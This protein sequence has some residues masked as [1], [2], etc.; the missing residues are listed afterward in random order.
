MAEK[1]K[2]MVVEDD[3]FLGL[4]VKEL[5]ESR[6]YDASLFKDGE[7]AQQ[8]FFEE[9][10]D[11]CVL[12]VMLPRKDGFTLAN[13]I[14][15]SGSN[16]PIVFLTAKSMTEDV[17]KGFK[18]GANDYVKKP[19]SMEELLVRVESILQRN[20]QVAAHQ[21]EVIQ[22]QEELFLLGNTHFNYT[23]QWLEVDGKQQ[24][25][26]P[27]EAE[28]LKMLCSERNKVV[29]RKLILVKLWG[30]DT[31]FNGRSLDVFIAKIR[32][33]LKHEPDLKIVTIRGEGYK[34]VSK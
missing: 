21:E 33:M 1:T 14:R 24:T 13:E 28:L 3:P 17:V 12:D 8:A 23:F 29:N 6:G 7:Q 5:F 27:R 19:F 30:D 31:F 32:K 34:L 15:Q 22:P 2:I 11:L 25:L 20:E 26:T 10:P 9:Q 4:I 16:V 18:L